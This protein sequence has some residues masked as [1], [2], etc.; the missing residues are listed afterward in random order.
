METFK[1]QIIDK[2]LLG[3]K[4][5][6]ALEKAG[7]NNTD[8]ASYMGIS[9]R[10]LYLLFKKDTFEIEYLRRASHLTGQPVTYFLDES[11]PFSEKSINKELQI[12]SQIPEYLNKI[13]EKFEQRYERIIKHYESLLSRYE[14]MPNFLDPNTGEPKMNLL[15]GDYDFEVEVRA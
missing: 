3:E 9:E 15:K 8:A 6:T 7:V 11:L 14:G 5:K 2:I 4:L 12:G 10:S 1:E 13:E